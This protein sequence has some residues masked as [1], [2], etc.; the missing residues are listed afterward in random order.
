MD[1]PRDDPCTL[2]DELLHEMQACHGP[3]LGGQVL[4]RALGLGS[5]AALRQARKRGHVTVALF[6]LPKRRG[7]YALTREVAAWLAT[8]RE[9]AQSATP[10]KEAPP[11]S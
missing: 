8:A 6:T 9:A 4:A 7:F 5:A 3:V 2:R 10:D 11:R 1:S